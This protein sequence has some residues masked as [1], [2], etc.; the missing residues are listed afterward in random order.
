MQGFIVRPGGSREYL[1]KEY[2]GTPE[3][4]YAHRMKEAMR[5][6]PRSIQMSR[7]AALEQ[8]RYLDSEVARLRAR[9]RKF[10][11]KTRL[12][13]HKDGI[14]VTESPRIRFAPRV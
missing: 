12:L 5:A 3:D 10:V 11:N 2:R 1:P 9:H 6:R 13:N 7:A 14:Q 8:D 4:Y